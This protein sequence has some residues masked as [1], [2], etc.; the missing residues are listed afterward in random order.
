M[1]YFTPKKF[2]D[3]FKKTLLPLNILSSFNPSVNPYVL[4]EGDCKIC[5]NVEPKNGSLCENMGLCE[6]KLPKRMAKSNEYTKTLTYP[7]GLTFKKIW[8]Y[9]YYSTANSQ[10]EYVLVVFASDNKIYYNNIYTINSTLNLLCQTTFTSTPEAICFRVSDQDVIGFCSP[11]DDMLVWYCDQLPYTVFTTPKFKSLC[12][13]NSR[14][15]AIDANKNFVVRYSSVLNPL[16]WQESQIETGGGEIVLNN[17]KGNLQ[18]VM[19][20]ENGIIVF[21]D[22]EISKINSFS[23]SS[24]QLVSNVYSSSCKIFANTACENLQ[25][26]YFLQQD[27]LCVFDGY[28]TEKLNFDLQGLLRDLP[29]DE[30]TSTFYN[31]TFYV[32][33][34]L[35][36]D[37][38]QTAPTANNALLCY[39]TTQKTISI[40]RGVNIASMITLCDLNTNILAACVEGE[41]KLYAICEGKNS[42]VSLQKKWAS[43]KITCSCPEKLKVLKSLSLI[44]NQACSFK[45]TTENQTKTFSISAKTGFQEISINMVG[46]CFEVEFSTNGTSFD[47]AKPMLNFVVQKY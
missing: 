17:F 4:K 30:A 45:I 14:L 41:E 20:F 24:M 33:C 2:S 9:K 21:S 19:S 28:K 37:D 43:G 44:C 7:S 6:I 13:N 47:I 1:R 34:K 22:Y 35:W 40:I 23:A 18:R 32:A 8:R 3:E 10:Y 42:T 46:R 12:I 29:Q 25:K 31:Q 5:Y 39:N 26:I 11:S 15:F 38:L 27:G 16:D 36:F